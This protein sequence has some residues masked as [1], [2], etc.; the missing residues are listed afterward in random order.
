MLGC[1]AVT[2]N[3]KKNEKK[4]LI[5][6]VLPINC[7][8]TNRPSI[9]LTHPCETRSCLDISHGRTPWC[10]IS[11]ILWR[12]MSGSGRPLTKTPPSWLTPPWPAHTCNVYFTQKIGRRIKQKISLLLLTNNRK[13]GAVLAQKFWGGALPHQPTHSSPSPFYPFRVKVEILA[14]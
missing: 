13:N 11:T 5:V 10:A 7:W 3:T 4:S 1:F 6:Y 2:K 8:T 12:T 9:L 14:F